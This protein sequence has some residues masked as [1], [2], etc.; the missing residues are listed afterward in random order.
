G[1]APTAA[2]APTG[3]GG[4]PAADRRAAE[5]DARLDVM[6][7]YWTLATARE[8]EK[9]L[10]ESLARTDAWVE[11]VKARVDSGLSPPS[12]VQ[13]A[14]AQ[15]ARQYVRL[16]QARNEAS[17]AQL[18]LARLIGAPAGASIHLT[19]PVEQALPKMTEV[20]ALSTDD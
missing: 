9:V 5:G 7:A 4:G 20:T 11:D 14:Q 2:P 15:R 8:S 13:S 12:D 18:D 6:R 1:G 10:V 16:L 17:L 3:G 19:S